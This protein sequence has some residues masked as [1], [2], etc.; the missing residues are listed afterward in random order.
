MQL[1][2]THRR[3]IIE[4]LLDIQIFTN[5]NLLLKEKISALKDKISSIE[6]VIEVAKQKTKVQKE[7]IDT[8]ESDKKNPTQQLGGT[9][10]CR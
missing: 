5:M 8:L 4:D 9:N 2:T 3:E 7:Y 1:P 10:Q 6:G